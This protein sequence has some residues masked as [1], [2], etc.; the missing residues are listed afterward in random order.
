VATLELASVV[1]TFDK[2]TIIHGVNLTVS[3]GEFVVFVGPSGCGKSTLLRIISGL[4]PASSGDIRIDGQRVND[5]SAAHRGCSMVFQ[6]YAL[7]PHMSVYDNMAFGLE[8]LGVAR[9][10]IESKVNAAAALLQLTPLLQRK[11]TQLS[12]GQRQRV[13]IG[14]SIVREPKLFLFD[15]PL[16]N[17]DAELR[18]S[19]RAEIRDLHARLGA[20]MIYVTHDQVEAMTMADKIVVLRAGR[21]EQ[22]GSPLELYNRPCNQ[23][24]AG[25]IGSPRMN[26]VPAAQ[27]PGAK[28]GAQTV[29]I[30]P[31]HAQLSDDGPLQLAVSQ[32]EQLGSTSILHGK[33]VADAP[34]ELILNGQTTI[35]RGDTVKVSAP[36]EQLHYFD[37]NGLRL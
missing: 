27:M 17:L 6:S 35:K 26:F 5:V 2:A 30:R 3:D 9:P 28:P 12:G 21:I 14:R 25:F 7:Y 22:V 34:F 20:T 29:G 1:K 13:A 16:S 4:E 33:V 36:A 10:V 32:V 11:P 15:E 8:N 23:F 19:M 37:A 24:V 18:V 31:E